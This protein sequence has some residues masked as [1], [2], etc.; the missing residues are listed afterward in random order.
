MATTV[1]Q[2]TGPV[3]AQPGFFIQSTHLIKHLALKPVKGGQAIKHANR[4]DS[5]DQRP[6]LA[7]PLFQYGLEKKSV[8]QTGLM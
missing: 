8:C 4:A 7:R 2:V 3:A 1:F 5:P 6:E